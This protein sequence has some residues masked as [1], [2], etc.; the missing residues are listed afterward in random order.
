MILEVFLQSHHMAKPSNNPHAHLGTDRNLTFHSGLDSHSVRAIIKKNQVRREV[1]TVMPTE[2]HCPQ[3]YQVPF[4]PFQPAQTHNPE[5]GRKLHLPVPRSA[6]FKNWMHMFLGNQQT[7][8]SKIKRLHMTKRYLR[9]K[10]KN[11]NQKQKPS[12][13]SWAG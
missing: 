1:G 8:F 10:T 5:W 3:Q 4:Q 9:E 11:K 12:R 2:P 6:V 7:L 13:L